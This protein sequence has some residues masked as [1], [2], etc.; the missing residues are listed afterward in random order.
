MLLD[1]FLHVFFNFIRGLF[2]L[3]EKRG[4]ISFMLGLFWSILL[5]LFRK[6][7]ILSIFGDSRG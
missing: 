6:Q 7:V 1:D 5:V 4:F 3:Q 2:D